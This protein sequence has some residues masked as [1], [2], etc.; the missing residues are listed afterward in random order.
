MM[1][2]KNLKDFDK[3]EL[4]RK[5]G[6]ET[7]R[8]TGATVLSMLAIFGVGIVVGAGVGMLLAP[9]AGRDLREDLRHRLQG[10]TEGLSETFAD[11]GIKLPER[12]R[13]S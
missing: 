8:S 13:A 3:D 2:L 12:P 11:D 4:L 5:I 6:L 10:A 1:T 9:K 7:K